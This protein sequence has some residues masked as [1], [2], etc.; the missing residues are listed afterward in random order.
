MVCCALAR[1]KAPQAS[2]NP[3]VTINVIHVIFI[4]NSSP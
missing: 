3:A 2:I 1:V 4:I